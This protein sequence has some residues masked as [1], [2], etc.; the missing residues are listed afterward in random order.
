MHKAAAITHLRMPCEEE[1]VKH[2][3]DRG[4]VLFPK[5]RGQDFYGQ[6]LEGVG[7]TTSRSEAWDFTL[8]EVDAGVGDLMTLAGET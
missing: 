2:K 6:L 7:L 5:Q 4:R 3:E 1:I 8:V